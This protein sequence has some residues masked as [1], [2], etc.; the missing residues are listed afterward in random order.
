MVQ[1]TARRSHM[2]CQ[3]CAGP[4]TA[5]YSVGRHCD[6]PS[7]CVSEREEG[8]ES[9]ILVFG[10]SEAP[11]LCLPRPTC[12]RWRAQDHKPGASEGVMHRPCLSQ[13][14]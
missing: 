12:V 9:R 13:Q 3:A 2:G 5:L 8:E 14:I 11:H 7:M 6:M 1:R 10:G 4:G